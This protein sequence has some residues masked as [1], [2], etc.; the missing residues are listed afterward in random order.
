[1]KDGLNIDGIEAFIFDFD[2]VLTSNLVHIDQNGKEWSCSRAEK[3][4]HCNA[5][6]VH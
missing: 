4:V 3:N 6:K 5:I 2:G 1:M